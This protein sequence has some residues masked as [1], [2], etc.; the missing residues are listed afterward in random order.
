MNGRQRLEAADNLGEQGQEYKRSVA[1]AA[2][3]R[4][5]EQRG[6]A[7]WLCAPDTQEWQGGAAAAFLIEPWAAVP[8]FC[9][10]HWCL[11]FPPFNLS[12]RNSALPHRACKDPQ[13]LLSG[14]GWVIPPCPTL[15]SPCKWDFVPHGTGTTGT[16]H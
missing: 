10:S 14:Q 7:V 1:R 13:F 2:A 12:P 8:I 5:R 15:P 9:A 11:S 4:E 3:P 6:G 16:C